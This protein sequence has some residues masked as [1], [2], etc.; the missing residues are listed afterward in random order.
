MGVSAVKNRPLHRSFAY[1]FPLA[2]ALVVLNGCFTNAPRWSE[3]DSG[4][5]KII[6]NRGGQTLGYAATS[7]VSIL[8]VDGFAFKDLSKNGVLD[9][10][11]DWRLPA[12]VRQ[13]RP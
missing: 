10:Y 6:S 4:P 12:N 5:I 13:L 9:P 7:G 1:V 2:A 3:T 11:E 8:T